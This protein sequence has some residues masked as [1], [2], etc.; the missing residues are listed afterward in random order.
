MQQFLKKSRKKFPK[1]VDK[2]FVLCYTLSILK[3]T[4]MEVRKMNTSDLYAEIA[5]CGL[6]V[7]RLAEMIGLNKKTMYTRMQGK[8]AFRQPEI[9]KIAEV[10]HLN[11]EKILS[12]FFADVVS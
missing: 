6:T 8:T 11:R 9:V 1:G 5:R 12:I 2:S 4:K 7:P 10:L 3:E